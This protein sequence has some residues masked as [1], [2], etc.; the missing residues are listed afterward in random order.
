MIQYALHGKEYLDVAR[1]YHNIWDTPTIKED[2]TGK[3]REVCAMDSIFIPIPIADA[4][5]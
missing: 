1:Y 4:A 5:L 3:G 2:T